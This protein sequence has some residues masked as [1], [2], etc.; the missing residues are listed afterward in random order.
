MTWKFPI[1]MTLL[2]ALVGCGDNDKDSGDAVVDLDGDGFDSSDDCDDDD[3]NVF[4]GASEV[5][6]GIDNDC[7]DQVDNDPV[8]GTAYYTDSDSDGFGD[9][10]NEVISCEPVDGSVTNNTDCNDNEAAANPEASEICDGIDNDCDS[11]VDDDDDSLDASTTG[12][13]Y[14]LDS[15]EDG[16]GDSVERVRACTAPAGYVEDGTDC[17]D[18]EATANPAAT[19]ICDTI[20]NDCDSFIDD[21]DDSLDGSTGTNYYEDF[22]EDGFGDP[23][24]LRQACIQPPGFVEDSTDCND[25]DNTTFPAATEICD[26]QYND[27]NN[28]DFDITA[29]P[30]DETDDDGDFYVECEGYTAGVTVT[31]ENVIAGSDCDDAAAGTNP[32]ATEVCDEADVDEDCDTFAD[33]DDESTSDESKFTYYADTD[34]DTFG[35]P[36]STTLA[37]SLP[38]GFVEDDQDCDDT[39]DFVN[40]DGS[41]VCDTLNLDEDCSGTAD[42]EDANVDDSTKSTFYL[43]SDGDD[44]GDPESPGDFCD[45]PEGY[46][47]DNTDCDDSRDDV[48]PEGDEV[49]DDDDVDENCNGLADD[50]DETTRN[51]SKTEYFADTDSDTFGDPENTTLACSLPEEGFVDNSQDCDDSTSAINPD[52]DEVC[53]ADNVDEDCDGNADDLDDDAVDEGKTDFYADADTDTFGNPEVIER[54]CDLP[55]SGFST[56]NTDCDDSRSDVNPDAD[57]VCDDANTDEDCDGNADDLDDDATDESKTDFYAD[58]D[59]DTFGDP[60]VI[61]RFCDLPEAGFSVNNTDCDDD[62]SDVNPDADEVCDADNVDEDCDGNADDLDDDAVDEGKTDFYADADTDTFG[63]PEVSERFCDLPESGFVVDNTDC[64]DSRS[65][66]NPDA[67]EVCD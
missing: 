55:E 25:N 26:G 1:A 21:A 8:D 15:D 13:F 29:A 42:D 38:T 54:F 33:D 47:D 2:L 14:Y 19:E 65:D 66:V 12:T 44:W 35:D 18:D 51:D 63:D 50:L 56:D 20:D 16:F 28:G 5:C 62:R 36:E 24:D 27:C 40:P 45:E 41:E 37:C 59:T 17:N 30:A 49:C 48:S 11:Q 10:S 39:R 53:D 52:A 4:P 22:D 9:P 23:G 64:D 61:E 31:D 7:D 58:T 43:D 32:G 57:E 46:V 67:D 34:E 3:A 6:D 60:E